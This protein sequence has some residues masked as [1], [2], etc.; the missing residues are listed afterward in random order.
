MHSFVAPVRSVYD[1]AA[2]SF[3]WKTYDCQSFHNQQDSVIL[4]KCVTGAGAY[5]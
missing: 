4:G 5:A 2:A 3:N 1:D